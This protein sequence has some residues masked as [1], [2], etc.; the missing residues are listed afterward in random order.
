MWTK[1]S[2][3]NKIL[4]Y[5]STFCVNKFVPNSF[6]WIMCLFT[7]IY[8]HSPSFIKTNC[9][10]KLSQRKYLCSYNFAK[11]QKERKRHSSV[12]W[13]RILQFFFSFL[14]INLS[15]ETDIREPLN[16]TECVRGEIYFKKNVCVVKNLIN[17]ALFILHGFGLWV[18][19]LLYRFLLIYFI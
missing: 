10:E 14:L 16:T 1:L 6:S 8:I 19:W 3:P 13:A 17:F 7:N 2:C 11:C 12:H 18:I 15:W 4:F 9:I 5:Y